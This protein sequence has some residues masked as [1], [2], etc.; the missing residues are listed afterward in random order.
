MK[1]FSVWLICA[2]LLSACQEPP[3][4]RDPYFFLQPSIPLSQPINFGKAGE[5]ADVTFWVLPSRNDYVAPS[6][7]VGFRVMVP[8]DA[9][10]S[11]IS[12]TTGSLNLEVIPLEVSLVRLSPS[13]VGKCGGRNDQS[14]SVC[15][16]NTGEKIF[17]GVISSK[18]PTSADFD[19]M[20]KKGLV[21]LRRQYLENELI[22][23]NKPHPGQYRLRLEVLKDNPT[24]A[25]FTS[26]LLVATY[27]KGK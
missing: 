1:T 20:L 27:N 14:Q 7:F 8:K 22:R 24:I 5:K 18:Q 3:P 26:E 23:V 25:G 4:E 11:S 10:A 9:D 19:Q 6:F 17:S 21:D 12:K 16:S 2:V 13:V 15:E